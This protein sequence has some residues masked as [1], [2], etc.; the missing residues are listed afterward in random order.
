MLLNIISVGSWGNRYIFIPGVWKRMGDSVSLKP[1]DNV[2]SGW[3]VG[4]IHCWTLP[5]CKGLNGFWTWEVWRHEHLH[6]P[7]PPNPPLSQDTFHPVSLCSTQQVAEKKRGAS[8]EKKV[9]KDASQV[10]SLG[11]EVWGQHGGGM[12]GVKWSRQAN[13][14][15]VY[16]LPDRE[17]TWGQVGAQSTRL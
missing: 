15:L 1:S 4:V 17:L 13:G 9:S 6:L 3:G 7:S 10:V 14:E 5:G 11:S 16:C 12:S 2:A 8:G